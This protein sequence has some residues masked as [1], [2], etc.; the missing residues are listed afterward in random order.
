MMS[1]AAVEYHSTTNDDYRC[2]VE[3]QFLTTVVLVLLALA[4]TG[5]RKSRNALV[6]TGSTT[7]KNSYRLQ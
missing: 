7:Q 4:T 5:V 1:V 6:T 3:S 2:H